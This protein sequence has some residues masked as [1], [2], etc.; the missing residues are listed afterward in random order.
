MSLSNT[1]ARAAKGTRFPVQRIIDLVQIL[2][3]TGAAAQ[4]TADAAML[5]LLQMGRAA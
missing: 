4:A 1:I 5:K 3:L 2:R